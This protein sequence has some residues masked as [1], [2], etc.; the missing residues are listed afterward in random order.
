MVEIFSFLNFYIGGHFENKKKPKS[1]TLSDD[2]FFQKDPL[3]GVNLTFFAP[4]LP[5]KQPPF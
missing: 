1:T 2:L 5:W 3:F 4:W